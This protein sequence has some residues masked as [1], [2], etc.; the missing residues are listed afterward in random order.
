M[1]GDRRF[2]TCHNLFWYC[3]RM[4]I[5]TAA[6][7][8]LQNW[9]DVHPRYAYTAQASERGPSGSDVV[10]TLRVTYD[11]ASKTETVHVAGGKGAGTD[12]R[13][14]GGPDVEVRGPGILHV[15]SARMSIHDARL[16]S[17]RGNDIRTA[18]FSRIVA[19]FN[20]AGDRVRVEST[21]PN[22]SVI[23]LTDPAGEQCGDEY[24]PDKITVDRLT[25][26]PHDG[27]PLMRE[28]LSG[29]I[30]LERWTIEDLR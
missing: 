15:V 1:F 27:R 2:Q 6:L 19:C 20:G 24:G 8:M 21:S 22:A 29:G 3:K 9:L 23:T 7:T 17:P 28:R 14:S 30:V 12:L 13:W 5:D 10:A 11:A 25:I 26:D 18:V 16:L 4:A